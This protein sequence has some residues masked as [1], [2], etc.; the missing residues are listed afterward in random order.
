M[1]EAAEANPSQVSQANYQKL[2]SLLDGTIERHFEG[3]FGQL[4]IRLNSGKSEQSSEFEI[5]LDYFATLT[6]CGKTAELHE[7]TVLSPNRALSFCS[8]VRI[9]STVYPER[10]V[11][12]DSDSDKPELRA[13][14]EGQV[15]A[16][17]DKFLNES[18]ESPAPQPVIQS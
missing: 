4:F 12:F 10:T 2:M 8:N 9:G 11:F 6:G 18:A 13:V 3:E 7:E 5:Q 1:V 15:F 16:T 17:V 14:V